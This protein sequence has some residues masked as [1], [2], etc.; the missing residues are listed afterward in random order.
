MRCVTA[1]RWPSSLMSRSASRTYSSNASDRIIVRVRDRIMEMF[2]GDVPG[3][4]GDAIQL[5]LGLGNLGL[6][7]GARDR[8]RC[9]MAVGY[10]FILEA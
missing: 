4:D 6:G 10:Q 8:W 2:R 1:R 9:L 5:G 3:I 7:L